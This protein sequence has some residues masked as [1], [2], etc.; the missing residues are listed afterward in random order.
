MYL[1]KAWERAASHT[2]KQRTK[3]KR[4]ARGAAEPFSLCSN[5]YGEYIIPQ[6]EKERADEIQN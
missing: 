5:L 4:T 3:T 1:M 6:K 2:L